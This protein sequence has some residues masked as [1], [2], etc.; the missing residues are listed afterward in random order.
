MYLISNAFQYAKQ[1]IF[2]Y[3]DSNSMVHRRIYVSIRSILSAL[4]VLL[5]SMSI[6]CALRFE[7]VGILIISVVLLMILI[8]I[9]LT[10]DIYGY[11]FG[12]FQYSL[13]PPF[14]LMAT[15][16]S[17]HNGKQLEEE[18]TDFTIELFMNM[19][20]VLVTMFIITRMMR[21][22]WKRRQIE[23]QALRIDVVRSMTV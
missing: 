16:V 7:H 18:M 4:F 20:G 22:K 12:Y 15:N 13:Y 1:V 8:I 3:P 6:I 11:I 17:I 9:R 21:K 19:I 5:C 14:D 23:L 10:F 2:Q